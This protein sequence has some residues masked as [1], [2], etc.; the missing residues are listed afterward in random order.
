MRDIAVLLTHSLLL[1]STPSAPGRELSVYPLFGRV[2]DLD[3]KQLL[4][5]LLRN[6]FC[7]HF[8][9]QILRCLICFQRLP[10]RLNFI[11]DMNT[12]LV[13]Q[14]LSPWP[15][16]EFQES[17]ATQE[18]DSSS[19]ENRTAGR[20]FSEPQILFSVTWGSWNSLSRRSP[21]IFVL[22]V[23]GTSDKAVT[24]LPASL[25]KWNPSHMNTNCGWWEHWEENPHN[26]SSVTK[27]IFELCVVLHMYF[28]F[29]CT[30]IWTRLAQP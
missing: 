23:M 8:R 11:F 29:I 2:P 28:S 6:L 20:S 9:S 7:R 19:C 24:W 3:L 18:C 1:L 26:Q 25:Y 4:F 14:K 12:R 17:G 21:N 22:R 30:D 16:C 13:W 5:T 15:L 10:W 27:E